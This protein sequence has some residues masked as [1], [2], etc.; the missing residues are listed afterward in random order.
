MRYLRTL[1]PLW[2]LLSSWVF[3]SSFASVPAWLGG[4]AGALGAATTA[5][6]RPTRP[7]PEVWAAQA[8]GIDP[9]LLYAACQWETRGE[10]ARGLEDRAVGDSGQARGRCQ[11][12]VGTAAYLMGLTAKDL[13]PRIEVAIQ[14]MLHDRHLNA[15]FAGLEFRWC[16]ENRSDTERAVGCYQGGRWSTWRGP[17]RGNKNVM[18]RFAAASRDAQA[19]THNL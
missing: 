9:L 13:T 17:T 4:S 6:S 11:V 3:C 7:A 15:L 2:L 1:L 12:Q 19:R 5:Q 10:R 14:T 16:L 8:V 18:S